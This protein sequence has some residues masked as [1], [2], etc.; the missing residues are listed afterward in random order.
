[1]TASISFAEGVFRGVSTPLPHK[2]GFYVGQCSGAGKLHG[3]LRSVE[4]RQNQ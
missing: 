1:M 2:G 4:L 3:V